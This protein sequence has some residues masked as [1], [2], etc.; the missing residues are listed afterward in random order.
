MAAT[1]QYRPPRRVSACSD[2][3]QA[4]LT[5]EAMQWSDGVVEKGTSRALVCSP[6][7]HRYNQGH[8]AAYMGELAVK[9][10]PPRQLGVLQHAFFVLAESA[11]AP[12]GRPLQQR[13]AC[14]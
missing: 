1:A 3:R 8:R 10:G 7:Q 13:V 14:K 11:F 2:E 9:Q 5:T 4:Q 12:G 6:I